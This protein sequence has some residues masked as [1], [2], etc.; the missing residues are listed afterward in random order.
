MTAMLHPWPDPASARSG[1][2]RPALFRGLSHHQ[3]RLV[4]RGFAL[5]TFDPIGRWRTAYPKP[6]GKETAAKVDASGKLP[7]GETYTDFASFKQVLQSS[8]QDLFTRSL[9]EKLLTYATGRY[10]EPTDRFEIDKIVDRVQA[11][12]N[13]LRTVVVEVLTSEIFRS[14]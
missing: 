12:D 14:R 10:M 6:K 9:V 1:V 5:E 8:R 11:G 3:L 13:G 4:R 2:T 7:S